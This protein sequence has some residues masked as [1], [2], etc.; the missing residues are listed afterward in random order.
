[1]TLRCHCGNTILVLFASED[2]WG[3]RCYDGHHL[4]PQQGVWHLFDGDKVQTKQW[5]W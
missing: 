4:G 5:K 2:R 3:L 1:M